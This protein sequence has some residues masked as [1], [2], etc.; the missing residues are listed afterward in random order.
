LIIIVLL[1]FKLFNTW[2]RPLDLPVY[3]KQ[4]QT[5]DDI[6]KLFTRKVRRPDEAAYQVIVDKNLF[7]PSRT[8]VTGGADSSEIY[9]SKETPQL[10][11]TTVMASG[12]FA[13][14]EDPTT[15]T[16][17]LYQI[18]DTVA[19][20]TVIDIKKDM[21]VLKKGSDTVEIKLREKKVFKPAKIPSATTKKPRPIRSK[22]RRTPPSRLTT[23]GNF[24]K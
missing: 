24:N 17:K 4:E 18:N 5:T 7:R 15:K 20:F 14:L 12:S 10:F 1:G 19:G 11:G 22:T 6:N 13:I 8:P 2:M 3:S 9:S 16:S 23:E 21:V